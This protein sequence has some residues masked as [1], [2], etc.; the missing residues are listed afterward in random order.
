MNVTTITVRDLLRG[1]KGIF[2]KVVDSPII[3]TQ[4][5]KPEVAIVS[6]NDL[7]I[8]QKQKE[9]NYTKNLMDLSNESKEYNI[10]G[11]RDLSINHDK[12]IWDE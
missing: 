7:K 5:N 12:Y 3:V 2:K 9:L 6:L 1:H 10:H 8:L 4:Y 11:P